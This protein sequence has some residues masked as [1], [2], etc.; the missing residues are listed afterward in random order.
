[1]RP[2]RAPEEPEGREVGHG[3]LESPPPSVRGLFV[4]SSDIFD[5]VR[6]WSKGNYTSATS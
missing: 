4:L 5:A 6:E 2:M 1:M 3:S